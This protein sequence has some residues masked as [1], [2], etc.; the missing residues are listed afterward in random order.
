MYQYAVKVIVTA[1]LVVAVAELSKRSTFWGAMLASLPLTSVLAF[2]WLYWDTGDTQRIAALSQGIL[3][4]VIPSLALF[5][6]LPVLL[7]AG[8]S[9]WASLTAAVLVTV[10][11]YGATVWCLRRVGVSA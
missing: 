8:F 9:F 5:A 2:I 1:V 4:L 11:A 7:R 10:L 3:W 6:V